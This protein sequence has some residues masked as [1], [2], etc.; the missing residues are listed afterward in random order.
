MHIRYLGE[1]ERI[2]KKK[3]RE[4]GKEGREKKGGKSEDEVR[5]KERGK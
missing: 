3:G 1:S 5:R 4:G 2:E